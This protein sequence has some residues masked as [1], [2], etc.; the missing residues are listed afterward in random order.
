MFYDIVKSVNI[1]ALLISLAVAFNT[2]CSISDTTIYL[3]NIEDNIYN[4]EKIEIIINKHDKNKHDVI[5]E[6]KELKSKLWQNVKA[7]Q[8][9]F[10]YDSDVVE[11][12]GVVR[13]GTAKN[14]ND[15][16]II[17]NWI[18]TLFNLYYLKKSIIDS[19]DTLEAL[20]GVDLTFTIL[21]PEKNRSSI[22]L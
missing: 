11:V 4:I 9:E 22:W 19:C 2:T 16:V 20:N 12:R 10:F 21:Q 1:D 15:C 14:L 3:A 6:K 8:K 7:K 5:A 13:Q 18:D 17:Q